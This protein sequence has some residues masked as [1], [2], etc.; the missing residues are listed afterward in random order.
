MQQLACAFIT[1]LQ[2][3]VQ[4]QPDAMTPHPQVML[5]ATMITT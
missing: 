3:Y 5:D 1:A 2:Q 4:L